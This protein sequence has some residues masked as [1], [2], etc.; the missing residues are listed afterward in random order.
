MI[1]LELISLIHSTFETGES[2]YV[3]VRAEFILNAPPIEISASTGRGL[4]KPGPETS[5]TVAE[6]RAKVFD[7][8]QAWAACGRVIQG[9]QK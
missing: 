1:S 7:L 8:E 4:G 2:P 6:V 9:D 3:F 5:A